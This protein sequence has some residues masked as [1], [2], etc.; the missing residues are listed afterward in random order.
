M[1]QASYI[2][3]SGEP[4]RLNLQASSELVTMLNWA[5]SPHVKKL[6]MAFV[7]VDE[8]LADVSDRLTGN[9]H[10]GAIECRCPTAATRDASS[11]RPRRCRSRVLGFR[12]DASWRS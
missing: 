3:P 9:P 2:F 1:D 6:N 4:G 5:M 8:K 7:L 12:C 11:R 10:V